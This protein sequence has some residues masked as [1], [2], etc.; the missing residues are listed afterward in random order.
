[1]QKNETH[2]SLIRIEEPENGIHPHRLDLLALLLQER[3][4]DDTEV[5]ATT[6]SPTLVDLIP[7]KSLYAKGTEKPQLT[8]SERTSQV[9][10]TGLDQ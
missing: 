7:Q 10:S 9:A 4:S 3:A 8:L 5:I 6:H 2:P 1:V